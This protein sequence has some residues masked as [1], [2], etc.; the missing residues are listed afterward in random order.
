MLRKSKDLYLNIE[1]GTVKELE[2]YSVYLNVLSRLA[3]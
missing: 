3:L 1:I 2:F